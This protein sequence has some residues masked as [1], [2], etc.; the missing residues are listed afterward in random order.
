MNKH[1]VQGVLIVAVV[2]GL[3][4]VVSSSALAQGRGPSG[5]GPPGGGPPGG[6]MGGP[7]GG[8]GGPGKGMGGPGSNFMSP[9]RPASNRTINSAGKSLQLGPPG[10][11]WDDKKFAAGLGLRTDQQKKMDAVF[12][13]NKGVILQRYETLQQEESKMAALT[14]ESKLQEDAIFAQV[15]R[16]S[17]A[18]AALE[19]ASA[20]LSL[21]LRQ[22]MDAEQITKL[23]Q[24]ASSPVSNGKD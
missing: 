16:V 19:K 12:N 14:S 1:R 18:R 2:A 6:G 15:D 20:H 11:W 9:S 3:L 5:G 17:Q 4:L 23:E 10:R 21:L 7:G 22:E 8:M 13:A 24:K